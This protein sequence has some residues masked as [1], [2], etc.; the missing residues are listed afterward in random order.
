M[1]A[2]HTPYD[3]AQLAA[4]RDRL[5]EVNA[6]LIE[7]LRIISDSWPP[8]GSD[9]VNNMADAMAAKARA[10]LAKAKGE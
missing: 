1:N 2:K 7:T 10:A 9:C 3:F 5:R 8:H 6:E 4:E